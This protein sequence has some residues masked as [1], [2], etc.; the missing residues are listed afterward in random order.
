MGVAGSCGPCSDI[1]PRFSR[2]EVDR[3]D[4]RDGIASFDR[5]HCRSVGGR[6]R[7]GT[8]DLR[9]T[10]RVDG[11]RAGG[12]MGGGVRGGLHGLAAPLARFGGIR[13]AGE[14]RPCE[15]S[16]PQAFAHRADDGEPRRALPPRE[17]RGGVRLLGDDRPS[18]S[19]R[20]RRRRGHHRLAATQRSF[21][22]RRGH[23][24]ADRRPLIAQRLPERV[25]Q[26]EAHTAREA[27]RGGCGC[28]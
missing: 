23:V 25:A 19:P 16:T 22:G 10:R 12:R 9:H 11:H 3:L 14:R 13:S 27:P 28:P 7:D 18:R 2:G 24:A 17:S 8:R 6:R 1:R 20:A 15:V 5:K 21:G 4:V 26:V